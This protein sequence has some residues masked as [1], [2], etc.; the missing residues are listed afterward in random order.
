MKFFILKVKTTYKLLTFFYK[1]N[2][3]IKNTEVFLFFPFY[4]TGGAEKVHADIVNSIKDIKTFIFFEGNSNSNSNKETFIKDSDYYEVFEFINRS[5]YIRKL[6]LIYL[7]RTINKSK[8]AKTV[9]ASNSSF[10]YRLIPHITNKI[11]KIDLTHA[12]SF[13][14]IGGEVSSLPYVPYLNHRIV[15][16]K[17]TLLDYKKLYV[18]NNL[19]A[20]FNKIK[21]IPNG[22]SLEKK[23]SLS[24]SYKYLKIGYVG[25]WS[26]EKRPELFLDIAEEVL[27]K[28]KKHCFYFIG[29]NSDKNEKVIEAKKVINLGEINDYNK[30]KSY[31]NQFNYLL[32]TSY[33]EGF[34]VVLMEAMNFG[35]VPICTDVGGISEHIQDGINGFL[36]DNYLDENKIKLKFTDKI[37]NT[38]FEQYLSMSKNAYEYAEENFSIETFNK[39]YRKILLKTIKDERD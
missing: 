9:F 3:S 6:F 39:C 35:V 11:S 25:R 21:I 19:N 24:K 23:I 15:I 29:N 5:K 31:Y 4:H 13:P 10:F 2:K 36:I 8:E 12:F 16:N 1:K 7:Y 18:K 28:E 30:L 27:K 34:P 37:L 38:S 20:Y 14:D 22:I 33:R 17:K 26:K 32:I